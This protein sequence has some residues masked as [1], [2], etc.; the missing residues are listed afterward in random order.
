MQFFWIFPFDLLGNKNRILLWFPP[1]CSRMIFCMF[2]CFPIVQFAGP[3]WAE[4]SGIFTNREQRASLFAGWQVFRSLKIPWL[5]G[6]RTFRQRFFVRAPVF[7]V[8]LR[9]RVFLAPEFWSTYQL[10]PKVNWSTCKYKR[11]FIALD[12]F[13]WQCKIFW[14]NEGLLVFPMFCFPLVQRR[15]I[16][17]WNIR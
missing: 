12:V 16:Y 1:V 5:L 4:T 2:Q 9:S 14:K 13:G 7:P 15:I 8:G 6:Y 10:R 3:L 11:Q 17:N